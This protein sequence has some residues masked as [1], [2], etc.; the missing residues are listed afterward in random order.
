MSYH[1]MNDGNI[2][3]SDAAC[4]ALSGMPPGVVPNITAPYRCQPC[5]YVNPNPTLRPADLD[6]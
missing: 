4:Y 1:C 6:P 2:Y 5:V 3:V